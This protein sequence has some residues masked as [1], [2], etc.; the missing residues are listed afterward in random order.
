MQY[1][2]EYQ[3]YVDRYDL[4][5]IEECLDIYKS[6]QK[7]IEEKDVV[8]QF[9]KYTKK[10]FTKELQ[11][12]L[13]MYLYT[14]KGERFVKKAK[15]IQEW[16]D[17]DRKEQEK[18][19]N[20]VPPLG[21]VCKSCKSP[22][23]VFNK[24]LMDS[25]GNSSQ[26]LFMFKCTKCKKNQAFYENG[27][28]W[29]YDPPTCPECN[30]S[31][32]SEHKDVDEVMTTTYSCS[33]CPYTKE[34]VYDFKKSR[35][36]REE[37][38]KK[39]KELLAKYREECCFSEKQGEEYIEFREASEV[40]KEVY[41]EELH[42]YD[43]TVYDQSLDVKKL[44]IVE[45]EKLLIEVLEKEKYIKL[46]FDRPEMTREVIVPFTV[47]DADSSRDE[48]TST[49]H[50]QK[51]L[52]N[53]LEK[54]NWRIMNDGI[55]YRLGYVYGKLKGYEGK[56]A[57]IE[58]L[59]KK[60]EKKQ[61]QIDIEK[62]NKYNSN[63]LVQLARVSGKVQREENARKRRLEK[64]PKGFPIS[65]GSCHICNTGLEYTSGWYDKYGFK[66]LNCQRATDSGILPPEVFEEENSWYNSWHIESEFHIPA[67]TIKKLVKQRILKPRIVKSDSG[68]D[69]AYVF[70]ALENN[71]LLEAYKKKHTIIFLC[72]IPVSG[73]STF[74]K[75]LEDKQGYTYISI[76][77]DVWPDTKLP[78]LWKDNFNAKRQYYAV[79]KFVC[80]LYENYQNVVIDWNFS[81]DQIE[82]A[83]LLHRQW[84]EVLWFSCSVAIARERFIKR[85][86]DS[87]T[88]FDNQ[89]KKLKA[90]TEKI[91]QRLE[92]KIID[93]LNEDR[94][95]KTM[96]DIYKDFVY[97]RLE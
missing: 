72:G 22:T 80:Y 62:R 42:K 65:F 58:L 68:R 48:K 13:N 69:H 35:M 94:T 88:Y 79:E 12:V 37:R 61:P 19:D 54:T 28:E 92:P 17:R 64:E 36:E 18:L 97:T 15:I 53:T 96:E 24:D 50:L 44:S 38:E 41:E 59:G 87:V 40:G 43:D 67:P 32:K 85:G 93:V 14:L 89:I 57:L 70:M 52:Q 51:I 74:G 73:K 77:K 26:V 20:A 90:N 55:H 27:K 56:D 39:E 60:K 3:H 95:N 5:T 49:T 83:S 11:K 25:Y 76:D 86:I 30:S 63:N 71:D 10:Q 66:C 4:H 78:S 2:Q 31:L 46:I 8:E 84:C 29:Q 1:L 16:M 75:Y 34:D 47:Q 33:K 45:L 7:G 23:T 21:I 9:K 91:T 81:I 6:I 82:V